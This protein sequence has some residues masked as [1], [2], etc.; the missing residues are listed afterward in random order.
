MNKEDYFKYY[1]QGSDHYLIPKDV[2]DE[3]FGEM[4]NWKQDTNKY[5]EVID[6]AIEYINNNWDGC[7]Y[8]DETLK[9]KV[10]EL[11]ITE[12]LDILKEVE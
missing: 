4:E 8:T 12:L 3:L 7:S 2:F 9:N 1:I 11:N 6:K 5:K 10:S